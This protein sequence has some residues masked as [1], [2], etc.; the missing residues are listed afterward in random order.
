MPGEA[1]EYK[2]SLTSWQDFGRPFVASQRYEIEIENKNVPW[3]RILEL[4]PG[5]NLCRRI[6]GKSVW[7][8]V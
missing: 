7:I 1:T 6:S 5:R 3:S 2:T 4:Q 8:F